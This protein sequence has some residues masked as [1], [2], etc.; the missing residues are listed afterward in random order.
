MAGHGR[1]LGVK[2]IAAIKEPGRHP[3]GDNLYLEVDGDRR[4]WFCRVTVNGRRREMGLGSVEDVTLA[5]AREKV[6]AARR[7]AAAGI[8]PIEARK[9]VTPRTPTFGEFADDLVDQI[10]PG[11]RNRKHIDQ[12]RMTLRVYAALLRDLRLDAITTEDVLAVLKPVWFTKAETAARVRGRIERVLDAAKARGY[13]AGENPAAWRGHLS[14]L[15]PRRQ[16]LTRGHHAAMPFDAVPGFVQQLRDRVGVAALAL[17]FLI[18]TAA[19]SG[20]VLGLTWDEIDLHQRVW[21]VPAQRMKAGR[22]HRAALVER[23][24]EIL[25]E[26]AKLRRGG[27]GDDWVFVGQRPGRPLSV[28]ALEMVLRRMGRADVTVHGFRS[29][30]R[31]WSGECTTHPREVAEA[32]LA[33]IVGDETERAY[34]RGDALEKRRALM[35]DWAA[36]VCP[37]DGVADSGT[38][39][40]G[41]V[42][43]DNLT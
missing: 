16:K 5:E 22:P 9:A 11:F 18:L 15:L 8:D 37:A 1:V 25:D 23:P 31:D 2:A 24:C 42:A 20:E 33:H 13:R 29:S 38:T 26:M 6:A 32:A 35:S 10:A 36:F 39:A 14:N 4:R 19:R 30:F 7:S 21:T 34:R 17:E 27:A 28:M 41:A 40:A 43:G 3:V 12:W